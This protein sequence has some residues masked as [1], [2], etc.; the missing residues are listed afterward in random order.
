MDFLLFQTYAPLVSWGEIAV[1]GERQSARHPSKSAIIGLVSA[2]FGIKRDEEETLFQLANSLG[3]AVELHAGGSILRDYHTT[4]VPKKE[5]K[6]VHYTRRSELQASPSKIG[7]ILSTREYRCDAL[8]VIAVYLKDEFSNFTLA[9][10]KQAICE[11]TFHLYFGRKSSPPALPLNPSIVKG[12]TLK[13]AFGKFKV[14]FVS[15][16]DDDNPEWLKTAF[17]NYPFHTLEDEQLTYFWEDGIDSGFK[18]LQTTKRYD[19]PS[20]RKRWQFSSRLEKM[21]IVPREEPA[22]VSQ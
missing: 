15:P 16:I 9:K 18:E 11:P 13:D 5:S 10:I 17:C 12:E 1:G 3:I 4:Q 6:V 8:A 22:N 20:S 19:Q 21:A 2:A 7:T 14:S